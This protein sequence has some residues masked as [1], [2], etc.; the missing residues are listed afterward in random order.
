MGTRE[1]W[2]KKKKSDP[3]LEGLMGRIYH[4]MR[5]KTVLQEG[6]CPLQR[7]SEKKSHAIPREKVA[8]LAGD[9]S[10]ELSPSSVSAPETRRVRSSSNSAHCTQRS[11]RVQGRDVNH[12]N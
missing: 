8:K 5:V 7:Y 11:A 4:L 10:T 1:N 3:K 9:Q 6:K 12:C 2:T